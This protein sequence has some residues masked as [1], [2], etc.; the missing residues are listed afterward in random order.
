MEERDEEEGFHE[1]FRRCLHRPLGGRP[2]KSLFLPLKLGTSILRYCRRRR[3]QEE[4]GRG[5][6]E[7]GRSSLMKCICSLTGEGKIRDVLARA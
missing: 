2:L 3:R 6:D 5:R 1:Y 7:E 4:E